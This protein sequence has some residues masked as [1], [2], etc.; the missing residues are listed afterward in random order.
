M[1]TYCNGDMSTLHSAIEWCYITPSND[2]ILLHCLCCVHLRKYIFTNIEEGSCASKLSACSY[3][4]LRMV[5]QCLSRWTHGSRRYSL[6]WKVVAG[7]SCNRRWTLK[8]WR[9]FWM[10]AW[11]KIIPEQSRMLFRMMYRVFTSQNIVQIVNCCHNITARW[12]RKVSSANLIAIVTVIGRVVHSRN[13]PQCED[14]PAICN[15]G[16]LNVSC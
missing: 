13:R 3:V 9:H 2:Q 8:Y 6:D 5:Q 16:Q 15:L 10:T 14:E 12:M 4:D 11:S 7:M 1:L